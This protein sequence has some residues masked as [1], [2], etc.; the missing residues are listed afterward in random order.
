MSLQ[1]LLLSTVVTVSVV[2]FCNLAQADSM[3]VNATVSYSS[4][5]LYGSAH[6]YSERLVN[7][8]VKAAP[9]MF[10]AFNDRNSNQ[11]NLL[12]Q[13]ASYSFS[14]KTNYAAN[15]AQV[16]GS[17]LHNN[18]RF[19]TGVWAVQ[20]SGGGVSTPEPGSLLLISTGL[21]GLAGTIRRKVRI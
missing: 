11:P 12:S 9:T 2:T 13:S 17:G 16:A 8:N 10:A 6:S 21:I 19:K 5:N 20:K 7:G 15:Y 18:L 3:P 14:T 4:A 1:R